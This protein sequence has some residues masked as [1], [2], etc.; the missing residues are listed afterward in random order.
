M[1]LKGEMNHWKNRFFIGMVI[2][3][4]VLLCAS[5]AIAEP[6]ETLVESFE[7]LSYQPV[8]TNVPE[9]AAIEGNAEIKLPSSAHEIQP[10]GKPQKEDEPSPQQEINRRLFSFGTINKRTI[11]V[12]ITTGML[13]IL[14]HLLIIP[15]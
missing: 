3:G 10:Y 9:I 6:T 1:K 7:S 8:P 12:T 11:T 4:V 13:Q 15:L 2:A 5:C 14:I